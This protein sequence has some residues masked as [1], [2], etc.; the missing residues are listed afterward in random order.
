MLRQKQEM[1]VSPK[2]ADLPDLEEES[3]SDIDESMSKKLVNIFLH[4]PNE[5]YSDIVPNY[6]AK[7]F[8]AKARPTESLI[9]VVNTP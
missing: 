5:K 4:L 9:P 1:N 8:S 3:D 6:P 7:F 2:K